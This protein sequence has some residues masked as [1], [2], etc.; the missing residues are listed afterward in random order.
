MSL[1][2]RLKID[3]QP[4][5]GIKVLSCSFGFSQDV[6]NRGMVASK[7][8][9]GTINL[10]IPHINDATIINWMLGHDTR[11]NGEIIFSGY[12]DGVPRQSIVF[13]DSVLIS[14]HE[15]FSDPSDT[16]ISLTI[17]CRKITVLDV[18]YENT[19]VT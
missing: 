11:K 12:S 7:V 1:A 14:Y 10:T 17:S 8:R 2:A 18:T 6:D 9:I 19:W 5:E 15:S 16:T 3:G 4:N 13:E